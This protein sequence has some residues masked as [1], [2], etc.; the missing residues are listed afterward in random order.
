MRSGGGWI[1]WVS[2]QH[3]LDMKA[4]LLHLVSSVIL[5]IPVACQDGQFQSPSMW[6]RTVS[7]DIALN[8]LTQGLPL[9][10]SNYFTLHHIFTL[11]WFTWWLECSHHCSCSWY[12]KLI[13]ST[14]YQFLRTAK[15]WLSKLIHS[16]VT[17]CPLLFCLLTH[18]TIVQR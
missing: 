3:Q 12:I 5:I 11:V 1:S 18:K 15:K 4:G 16:S 7:S 6:L 14:M 8:L 2:M 9:S 17:G 13:T 10:C